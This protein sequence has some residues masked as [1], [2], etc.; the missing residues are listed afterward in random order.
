M[1]YI[2]TQSTSRN[3]FCNK[4]VLKKAEMMLTTSELCSPSTQKRVCICFFFHPGN[5]AD[6]FIWETFQPG[7]R[8]LGWNNQ[9]LGN[10]AS[11]P[12]HMNTSKFLQRK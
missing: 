1:L 3:H 4:K 10:Q 7:Y 12:F 2:F 11:P 8:D 6:M 5:R 9:D